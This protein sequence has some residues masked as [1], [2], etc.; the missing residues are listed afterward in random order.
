MP[1]HWSNRGTVLVQLGRHHYAFYRGFLDGLDLRVLARRY[2]ETNVDDGASEMDLRTAR[3]MVSWIRGQL[4]LSARRMAGASAARVIGLTP[5]KLRIRY[6]S[7]VPTLEEFREE[8]DPYE[9]YTEQELIALFQAEYAGAAAMERRAGRNQRLRLKQ[10]ALLRQLEDGGGADPHAG[11]AVEAWLDAAIAKR[12]RAVKIDTIGSLVEAINHHGYRWYA[13]VPRVGIK[14]ARQIL[15]WLLLPETMQSVGL[16]FTLRGLKPRRQLTPAMLAPAER[17][18]GIVALEYFC[19]PGSMENRAS[20]NRGPDASAIARNDL[21]AIHGWLGQYEGHGNTFRAYRKEAE[22]LLMWSVLEAGKPLG[23]LDQDDCR[24]YR[25]FLWHLGRLTPEQW[26]LHFKLP[27]ESWLGP[28]GVDRSSPL[29]RPFEGCLSASSQK[30]ALVIAQSMMAWL[31]RQGYLASNPF[32]G[33]VH[34]ARREREGIDASRSLSMAEWDG[35]RA[36]LAGLPNDG[37]TL[38][39]RAILALAYGAGCRLSELAALRRSALSQVAASGWELAV[40]GKDGR[41]RRLPLGRDPVQELTA[42]FRWRGFAGL[43]LAPAE[44]P[45]IASLPADEKAVATEA[46]LSASRIY[47]VL[48]SFFEAAAVSL[49]A[50]VEQEAQAEKL[51]RTSTHWLRHSFAIHSL[52]KGISVEG[53]RHMLGHKSSVSTLAYARLRRAESMPRDASP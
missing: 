23:S 9:T 14:A 19:L 16:P 21:E 31:V 36:Y 51:A 49:A 35:L 25:D 2:L 5:D 45:M 15:D 30:T 1:A 53:L 44:T 29:W 24:A 28:R 42:Y 4:V 10:L 40:A 11:D 20:G 50:K 22:R 37:R 13:K 33:L 7:P 46:A 12:L 47:R 3:G 43:E 18:T 38:R 34:L 41:V 8:R 27:Q 39:L 6:A 26:R 52:E 32:K 17:R 48:K